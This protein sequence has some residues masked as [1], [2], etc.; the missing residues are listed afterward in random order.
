MADITIS[1]NEEDIVGIKIHQADRT[2]TDVCL[3]PCKMKENL[4]PNA[5]TVY[6]LYT[7]ASIINI[8]YSAEDL[9]DMRNAH[10]SKLSGI[11]TNTLEEVTVVQASHAA[12]NWQ[13]SKSRH[14]VCR[15]KGSCVTNKS[16]C[17]KMGNKCSTK[18]HVGSTCCQNRL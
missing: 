9:A 11:D 4:Q 14:D 7:L 2:N 10:F 12:S 15:C 3:L 1:Y 18:C 6:R 16:C 17:R 13:A 5:K 8:H